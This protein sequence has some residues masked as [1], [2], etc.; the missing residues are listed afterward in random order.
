[1]SLL[2][3]NTFILKID[4]K[5]NKT[6]KKKRDLIKYQVM[7]KSL[8]ALNMNMKRPLKKVNLKVP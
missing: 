6:K 8:K 3:N 7:K 5:Y 2:F 1:M 4:K